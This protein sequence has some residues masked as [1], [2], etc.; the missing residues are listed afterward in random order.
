MKGSGNRTPG[1]RKPVNEVS[2][3][4]MLK[5]VSIFLAAILWYYVGGEDTVDKSVMVPIEIINLP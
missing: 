5:L 2:R 3:E 4:W 1:S